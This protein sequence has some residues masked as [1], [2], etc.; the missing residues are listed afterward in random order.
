MRPLG[1]VKLAMVFIFRSIFN[2]VDYTDSFTTEVKK[3]WQT[4]ELGFIIG[5]GFSLAAL[6]QL[7]TY[8]RN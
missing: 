6:W 5:V 2:P 3:N 4:N 7:Q 8:R 1:P